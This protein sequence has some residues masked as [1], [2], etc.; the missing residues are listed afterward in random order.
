MDFFYISLASS[1]RISSDQSIV[2]VNSELELSQ[3]HILK[4]IVS[5]LNVTNL[6]TSL[7][8]SDI[9][10]LIRL[11]LLKLHLLPILDSSLS[12]PF[13]AS[14]RAN[15]RVIEF[16]LLVET[17]TF[18]LSKQSQCLFRFMCFGCQPNHVGKQHL[19]S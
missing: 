19:I 13:C 18:Q 4:S 15:Y 9:S 8:N 5:S 12:I 2:I 16:G 7:K 17:I 11:N 10:M 6:R 1:T 3:S 14:Q